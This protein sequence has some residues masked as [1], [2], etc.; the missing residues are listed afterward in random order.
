MRTFSWSHH[1]ESHSI[2]SQ[3]HSCTLTSVQTHSLVVMCTQWVSRSC[4]M[5]SH[6]RSCTL[7]G[8]SGA[9]PTH[10]LPFMHTKWVFRGCSH[11]LIAVH[12]HSQV[13]TKCS[14]CVQPVN[15]SEGPM[16]MVSNLR[17]T[18][19]PYKLALNFH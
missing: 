4:S 1:G 14:T 5:L 13:S 11:S 6:W 8:C 18:Q 15:V 3:W 10:S 9:V 12:V 7:N 19:R 17:S 2:M 16:N